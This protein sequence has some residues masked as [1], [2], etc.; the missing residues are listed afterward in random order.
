MLINGQD[1]DF[2]RL[3]AQMNIALELSGSDQVFESKASCIGHH[4]D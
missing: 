3:A 2:V 4:S 1:N